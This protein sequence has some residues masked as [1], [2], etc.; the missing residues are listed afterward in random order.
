M[1]DYPNQQYAP[2][3]GQANGRTAAPDLDPTSLLT[4]IEKLIAERDAARASAEEERGKAERAVADYA[5]LRRRTETDREAELDRARSS[6]LLAVLELADDFALA[7][8]HLPAAL[9]ESPWFAGIAAI[10]R[11]LAVLLAR[12]GVSPLEVLGLPFDPREHE[13]VVYLAGNGIPEGEVV[14]EIRRGYRL[15]ERVLRPAL[16]GVSDGGPAEAPVA[17]SSE[18]PPP[19]PP[20]SI[21]ELLGTAYDD[22]RESSPSLGSTFKSAS[23]TEEDIEVPDEPGAEALEDWEAEGGQ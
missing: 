4:Q 23:G 2:P 10:E 8:A 9:E 6:L 17:S 20:I 16:V 22:E 13:A 11:K 21:A 3:P 14:Q 7:I 5:N 19:P 15:N 1:A 18:W 12:E